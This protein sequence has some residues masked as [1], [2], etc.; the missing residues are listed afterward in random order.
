MAQDRHK[1]IPAVYLVLIKDNK[2]LLC[3]RCNT[4]FCD[5]EYSLISGHFEAGESARMAMQREAKEEA[6]MDIDLDDLEM[7]QV[8]SRGQNYLDY[9]NERVDFFFTLK[10]WEKDPENTEP[11]KCDDMQ[12]F[13]L[14]N[15]P[16]NTADFIRH[17]IECYRK[18]EVY[19]E[20]GWQNRGAG[21]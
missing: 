2:T 20:F 17:F 19:S 10:K 12:W 11:E 7:V 6:G 15:L 13:S 18:G 14:D 16:E 21:V 4:G 9:N 8:M 3:R 1:I 5:G